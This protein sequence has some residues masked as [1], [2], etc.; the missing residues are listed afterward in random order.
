[1]S[2]HKVTLGLIQSATFYTILEGLGRI[3]LGG[4]PAPLFI[5]T[6][7]TVDPVRL[8][9]IGSSA[10]ALLL[11]GE[12]EVIDVIM[13]TRTGD[14]EYMLTT[15]PQTCSEVLAWLEAHSTI[16]DD[17]GLV[18]EGL[19]LTDET[20]SLKTIA[21]YGSDSH[22]IVDD[23][24]AHQLAD[25]LG[26]GSSGL[27]ELDGI[28]AFVLAYPLLPE[29]YFELSVAPDL[30]ALLENILLSFPEI[31]PSSFEEYRNARLQA[32]TWF[33]GA[34]EAEY[35]GVDTPQLAAL[36]RTAH[37]FVGARSLTKGTAD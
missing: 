32:G 2:H 28:P 31:D 37:D 11:T 36:I 9:Q 33:A 29:G 1:M 26:S 20:E 8:A 23:L 10:P 5:H 15:H 27:C 12:A 4:A 34:E 30:V 18:F 24:A 13:V 22:G 19:E 21:V 35:H 7:T 6:M 14:T 16:C 17:D 25:T 3:R